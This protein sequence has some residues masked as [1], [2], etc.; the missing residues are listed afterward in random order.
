MSTSEFG[1]WVFSGTRTTAIEGDSQQLG[2]KKW[3]VITVIKLCDGHEIFL[4]ECLVARSCGNNCA[5]CTTC[6]LN[7]E[8]QFSKGPVS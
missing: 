2:G 6:K 4:K 1:H 8:G 5:F 3:Q 7:P